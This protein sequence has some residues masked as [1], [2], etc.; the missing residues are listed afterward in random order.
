MIREKKKKEKT[1][2]GIAF[3]VVE[4]HMTALDMVDDLKAIKRWIKSE[5]P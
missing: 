3:I 4:S 1:N 5:N 2:F